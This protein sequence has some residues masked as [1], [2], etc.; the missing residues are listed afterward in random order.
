MENELDR[1][2]RRAQEL[3]GQLALDI[4]ELVARLQPRRMVRNVASHAHDTRAGGDLGRDIVRDMRYNPIPYLLAG[5]GI[6]GLIWAVTSLSR[7][8]TRARLPEF[9]EADFAPPAS[10]RP[11]ATTPMTAAA[12]ASATPRPASPAAAA[13]AR[14]ISPATSAQ[15]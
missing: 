7:R 13:P 2:E 8:R 6:A 12:A 9:S 3:R 4:D 5:I 11:A 15:R 1:I 14:D 10:P